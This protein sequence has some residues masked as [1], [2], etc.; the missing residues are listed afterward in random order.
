[1]YPQICITKKSIN[2]GTIS[3]LKGNQ[4]EKS[5]HPILLLVRKISK[6]EAFAK[7]TS[8][9]TNPKYLPKGI[10][11]AATPEIENNRPTSRRCVHPLS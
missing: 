3:K 8:V 10:E 2:Y 9:I 7:F 1:M 5:R 11:Y 4:G 6:I